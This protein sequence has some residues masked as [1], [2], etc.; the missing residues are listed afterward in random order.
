MRQ[1]KNQQKL[2]DLHFDKY[3]QNIKLC[4]HIFFEYA[5]S[6]LR[7]MLPEYQNSNIHDS[8]NGIIYC[9]ECIIERLR[10]G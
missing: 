6:K 3:T 9:P 1:L 8:E 5:N 7:A 2:A 10:N 4:C